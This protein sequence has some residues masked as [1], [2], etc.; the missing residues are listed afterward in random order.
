MDMTLVRHWLRKFAL[1]F[2]LVGAGLVAL[3]AVRDGIAGIAYAEAA[4]WAVLAATLSASIN[5]WWAWKHGCRV[6][7]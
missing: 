7:S 6:R 3:Y 5:T 2:V 1:V 4:L